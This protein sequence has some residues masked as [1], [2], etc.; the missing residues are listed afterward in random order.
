MTQP[1]RV[2]IVDDHPVVR[3]GLVGLLETQTDI[4]VIGQANNGREAIAAAIKS[5]PDLVLIDLQ[6]PEMGGTEAIAAIKERIPACEILVLTTYDTD[7][8]IL[9]AI[10]AGATG[11]L[12]KDARRE[13]LFRA[14]R[15]AANGTPALSPV[16][17]RRL[18]EHTRRPT[19]ETL[20][21]REIE[22]LERAARGNTNADIAAD[23]LLSEATV[24]S[25]LAHI[26]RKLAVHDRTA[27]VTT[28]LDKGI[29]RIV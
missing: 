28:A 26:Y 17:A 8:D 14:V 19:F 10:E 7:A 23:M 5:E 20:T 13:E 4:E 15:E 27:A 6:M 12:L 11:Y 16:V 1:I 25:H 22:V 18:L 9:H 24:K 2:L 3:E 29:I 21:S